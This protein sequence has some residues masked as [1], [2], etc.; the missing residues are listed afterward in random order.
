MTKFAVGERVKWVVGKGLLGWDK[1]LDGDVVEVVPEGVLPA[2]CVDLGYMGTTYI[3]E[4]QNGRG[5]T[6]R[7]WFD[8]KDLKKM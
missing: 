1:F 5:R 3:V 2:G 4:R 6:S 8:E 7:Y